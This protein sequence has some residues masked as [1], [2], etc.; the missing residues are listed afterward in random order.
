MGSGSTKSRTQVSPVGGERG[1]QP[2]S[3]PKKR[4]RIGAET[5][6]YHGQAWGFGTG[7]PELHRERRQSRSNTGRVG[8]VCS[9]RANW[10][11][12]ILWLPGKHTAEL[13][14]FRTREFLEGQ[15]STDPLK[16]GNS[17]AIDGATC[18]SKYRYRGKAKSLTPASI[19][20]P[21][22]LSPAPCSQFLL[23]VVGGVLPKAVPLV[24]RSARWV[25]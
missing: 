24:P 1:R 16:R 5:L 18:A 12:G 6:G 22:P 4:K 9:R 15:L 10:G 19:R 20:S 17:D 23:R 3:C 21:P 11:P 7:R 2:L 8:R 25:Q 14:S 13:G